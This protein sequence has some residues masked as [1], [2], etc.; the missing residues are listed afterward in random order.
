MV[1][2]VVMGLAASGVVVVVDV[3]PGVVVLGVVVVGVGV[4]VA[5]LPGVR[6]V[7]VVDMLPALGVEI[8]EVVVVVLGGGVGVVVVVGATPAEEIEHE[9]PLRDAV[10]STAVPGGSG[11]SLGVHEPAERFST[12]AR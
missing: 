8:D 6:G 11:A 2:E 10:G 3:L 9:T 5:L 7:V 4:G 1:H 12:R